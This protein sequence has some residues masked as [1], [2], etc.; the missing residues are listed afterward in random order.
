M[1]KQDVPGGTITELYQTVSNMSGAFLE[2]DANNKLQ[3]SYLDPECKERAL[4]LLYRAHIQLDEDPR[5][6]HVLAL[7]GYEEHSVPSSSTAAVSIPQ[8]YALYPACPVSIS[9]NSPLDASHAMEST[10]DWITTGK[11]LFRLRRLGGWFGSM[12]H[13]EDAAALPELEKT[14][15]RNVRSV[16]GRVHILTEY[17]LDFH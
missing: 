13:S 14:L 8:T 16:Q 11:S 12:G 15:A 1:N 2:T 6:A 17:A 7:T 5:T 9:I 4:E 10:N 3:I